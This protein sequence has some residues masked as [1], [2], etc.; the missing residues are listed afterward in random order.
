MSH[1][2]VSE[3]KYLNYLYERQTEKIFYCR[4][5]KTRDSHLSCH[6]HKFRYYDEPEIPPLE[7]ISS[8]LKGS[9]DS[10]PFSCGLL[11]DFVREFFEYFPVRTVLS[12]Y[13]PGYLNKKLAFSLG[14]CAEF[15]LYS[16]QNNFNKYNAYEYDCD[17]NV[18]RITLGVERGNSLFF[19]LIYK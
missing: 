2:A 4:C 17:G 8:V 15:E 6:L 7:L 18:I 3:R 16:D 11:P 12:G 1:V 13:I 10:I 9:F 5:F 19:G 14:H